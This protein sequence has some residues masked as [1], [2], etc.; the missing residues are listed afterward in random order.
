[1]IAVTL[2]TG[3]LIAIERRKPRGMMLLRTAQEHRA[4]L[5]TI[6]PVVAERWRG[7]TD[8]RDR[9]KRIVELVPRPLAATE[10]AGRARSELPPR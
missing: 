8:E 6:T 3:A 7:R 10:A 4:R 5:V 2:D 1:M 9:I